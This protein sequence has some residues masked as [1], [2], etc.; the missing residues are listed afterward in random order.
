MVIIPALGKPGELHVW[1][2]LSMKAVS[3]SADALARAMISAGSSGTSLPLGLP[4]QVIVSAG[5]IGVLVG[6]VRIL[7]CE[8]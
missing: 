3:V 2:A 4:T 6:W 8:E 7:M 5:L 1:A